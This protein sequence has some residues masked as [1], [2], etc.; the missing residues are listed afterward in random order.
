[1]TEY[2]LL[3]STAGSLISG[4]IGDRLFRGNTNLAEAPGVAAAALPASALLDQTAGVH[5]NVGVPFKGHLGSSFVRS[6]GTA[7]KPAFRQLDVYGADL[8]IAPIKLLRVEGEYAYSQWRD[9]TGHGAGNLHNND[10]TAW[11]GKV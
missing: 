6:A 4:R 10:R 2:T 1:Q 3:T 8:A 7:G 5:V 9:Q 11:D